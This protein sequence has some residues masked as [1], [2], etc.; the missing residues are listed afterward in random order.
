MQ[1]NLNAKGAVC[2]SNL[3]NC[4]H[5]VYNIN[6]NV[7]RL[8]AFFYL[9]YK[10]ADSTHVSVSIVLYD[11]KLLCDSV[12]WMCPLWCQTAVCEADLR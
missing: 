6:T 12:F 5:F 2:D 1:S 3:L 9:L 10:T 7:I 11:S 8:N 4:H